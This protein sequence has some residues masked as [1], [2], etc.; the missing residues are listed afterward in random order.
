M[1]LVEDYVRDSQKLIEDSLFV[2][3]QLEEHTAEAIEYYE[4]EKDE[5][6]A[7]EIRM[8]FAD[9]SVTLKH[10]ISKLEQLK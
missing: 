4:E 6:E 3:T 2:L 1:K 9:I 7:D 10:V 8:M 5:D